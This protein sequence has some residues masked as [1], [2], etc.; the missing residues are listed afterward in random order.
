MGLIA[1][2]TIIFVLN[3]LAHAKCLNIFYD[4][5]PHIPEKDKSKYFGKIH[6]IFLQNLAGHFP[7]V[8]QYLIPIELYQKGDIDAC[9]ASIYLGTYFDNPIPKN[10]LN[11][12]V[13]TN[14]QVVWAGYNI[15]QLS[16]DTL[17]KLWKVK[18]LRQTSIEFDH[19]DKDGLPGFFRQF[20]YKGEV[21]EKF[22]ELNKS[23]PN[24]FWGHY[25]ITEF[26][27]D[28]EALES[29][30]LSWARHSTSGREI[31]YILRSQNHWYI[32]DSPFSFAHEEDRYLI[33]ADLLFD[34]LGEPAKHK[35]KPAFFRIE[36]IHPRIPLWQ[37][38]T[39]SRMLERHDIP[40]SIAL[41]PFFYDPQGVISGSKDD[42]SPL[43]REPLFLDYLD[44]A[45]AGG[46]KLIYHGVTHQYGREANPFDATSGSDFEF[47]DVVRNRPVA[48]DSPEFVI[49]RIEDGIDAFDAAGFQPLAWE[50]PHYQA[51]PLDYVIFGQLFHWNMGR[52]IYFP[53]RPYSPPKLPS[54]L[55][56]D[57]GWKSA[58][59]QRLKHF[60]G[61]EV[62]YPEHILPNGQFFPYEIYGDIYGQ[63]ILPENV[64]N[65]QP[66][67]S[68]HVPR[69]KALDDLI[70]IVRRNRVLRDVWASFFVH[71]H[72]L[73][74]TERWGM[75]RFNGDTRKIET[76]IEEIKRQ[77]YEFVDLKE[78]TQRSS[79]RRR[80][81][82][83]ERHF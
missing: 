45:R 70:R 49:R 48:K 10:F 39:L 61:L 42:F 33:F 76:L 53:T 52:V 3:P 21:F 27:F 6:S 7:N 56:V 67:M 51:S 68:P 69:P 15:W 64:G 75:G 65:F 73:G 74:T 38:Y 46:A 57:R 11:D 44:Y 18:Y 26:E 80:P 54:H 30:T 32:G 81:P 1:A 62:S 79:T 14:K 35:V 82:T 8:Q 22:A 5:L 43:N 34:I 12:F 9:E 72:L 63:R 60:E 13:Q 4:G 20:T 40:Y 58:K 71:A 55:T 47:W 66:Y 41:I 83:I 25:E 24:G 37:L 50:V 31:P 19:L 78:F 23:A 29:I 17:Q 16:N 28:R 2:L 36:D 77:G 59:S